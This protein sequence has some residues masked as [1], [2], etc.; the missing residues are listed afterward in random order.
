MRDGTILG[1]GGMGKGSRHTLECHRRGCHPAILI[2]PKQSCRSTRARSPGRVWTKLRTD[3]AAHSAP[4]WFGRRQID[5]IRSLGGASD[6][7]DDLLHL[8]TDGRG[9]RRRPH[10]HVENAWH[11]R[12]HGDA[13]SEDRRSRADAVHATDQARSAPASLQTPS[14][15]AAT[16]SK[17]EF[18]SGDGSS[19]GIG[20][21]RS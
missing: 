12:L 1:C 14:T 8:G 17:K 15:T 3:P 16:S 21:A 19:S 10:W 2:T 4:R 13:R 9:D 7:P 11:R 5:R 6:G 18:R 20:A